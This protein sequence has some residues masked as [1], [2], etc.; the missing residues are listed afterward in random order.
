MHDYIGRVIQILDEYR[1]IVDAGKEDLLLHDIIEVYGTGD[2]ILDLEG[3]NLGPL[4]LVK[5][6]LEV[7]QVEEKY[8]IC[9]KNETKVE[10]RQSLSEIALSPLFAAP[11]SPKR[12]PLNL[13]DDVS[14][15]SSNICPGIC[16]GDYVRKA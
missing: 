16:V 10:K 3:N 9:E 15:Q 6:R 8:S 4:I 12:I 2:D 14:F 5:D 1:I 13:E 11:P 7:S